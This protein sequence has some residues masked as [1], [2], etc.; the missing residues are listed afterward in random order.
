MH[1]FKTKSKNIPVKDYNVALGV[2]KMKRYSYQ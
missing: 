2:G 1:Y